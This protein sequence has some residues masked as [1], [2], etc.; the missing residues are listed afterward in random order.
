MSM[1]SRQELLNAHASMNGTPPVDV[2][3]VS[4]TAELKAKLA[5]D[6]ASFAFGLALFALSLSIYVYLKKEVS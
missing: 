2:E 6:L 4:N 3:I 5:Y 1:W